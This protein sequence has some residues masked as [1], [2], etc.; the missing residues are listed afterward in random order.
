[1]IMMVFYFLQIKE[2]KK[3]LKTKDGHFS[4]QGTF[5]MI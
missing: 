1:V 3:L 5:I 4:P 2:L